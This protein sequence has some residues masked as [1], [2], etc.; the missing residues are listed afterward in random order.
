MNK[1]VVCLKWG[2]NVYNAEYVNRLYRAVARHLSPPFNFV[3]FTDETEGMESAIEAR[4]ITSLTFAPELQG[5]WWKLAVMHPDAKLSEGGR[6]LFLDLDNII[7]SDLECFFNYKQESF[8]VI[9]NWI[10]WRKLIFRARPKIFNSSVFRFQAGAYPQVAE[11]FMKNPT[12]ALNRKKF[13]T[14]QSFMTHAI[15]AENAA[16]W[17]H[18]WVK[19]YKYH[20]RPPFPLNLI[21]TPTIPRNAKIL[22]LTGYPKPHQAIAEGAK[23]GWHR[24]ILPM[25]ELKK[26]WY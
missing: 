18:E 24:R 2:R 19:S 14:E 23:S 11:L 26:H 7:V 22:C 21:K 16:W 12:E 13:S 6:C 5:I 10:N 3:C 15:G 25:P 17:P 4:D 9:H 20:M 8:C 1:T